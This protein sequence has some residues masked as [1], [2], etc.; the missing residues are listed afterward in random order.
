MKFSAIMYCVWERVVYVRGMTKTSAP[1]RV[2]IVSQLC[3]SP[4]IIRTS[5]AQLSHLYVHFLFKDG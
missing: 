4:A 5:A 1:V 3:D 2:L